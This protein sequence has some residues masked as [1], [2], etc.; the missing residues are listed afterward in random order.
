MRVNTVGGLMEEAGG[1]GYGKVG[2][3]LVWGGG[4]VQRDD[5]CIQIE[6]QRRNRYEES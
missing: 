3:D 5:I 1:G 6:K 2:E 4:S